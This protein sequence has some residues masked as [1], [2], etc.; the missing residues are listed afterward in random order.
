MSK[1]VEK[2]RYAELVKMSPAELIK[3]L[4]AI[5]SSLH[6]ATMELRA[7]KLKNTAVIKVKKA[8]IARVLTALNEKARSL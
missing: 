8:E 7:G 2:L 5:R 4:S 3:Q 6:E 1:T